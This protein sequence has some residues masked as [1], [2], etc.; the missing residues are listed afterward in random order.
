MNIKSKMQTQQVCSLC[1]PVFEDLRDHAEESDGKRA[2]SH[3]Y[4]LDPRNLASRRKTDT[5][6]VPGYI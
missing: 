5:P 6:G 1:V 4:Q 3:R 2:D